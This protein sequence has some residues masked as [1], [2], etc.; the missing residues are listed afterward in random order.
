MMIHREQLPGSSLVEQS[1]GESRN[2]TSK[3]QASSDSSS[4]N[5]KTIE[6]AGEIRQK[7]KRKRLFADSHPLQS[8]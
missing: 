8:P 4:D 6:N 3:N 1:V 7:L 2:I 5:E